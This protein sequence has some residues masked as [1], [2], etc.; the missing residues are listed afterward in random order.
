MPCCVSHLQLK[1]VF[2]FPLILDLIE[3]FDKVYNDLSWPKKL[4]FPA[5]LTPCAN[6][7]V[8]TSQIAFYLCANIYLAKPLPEC[9]AVISNLNFNCLH[10]LAQRQ[11]LFHSPSPPRSFLPPPF[12]VSPFA[13]FVC[14]NFPHLS[15]SLFAIILL[16]ILVGE[17]VGRLRSHV[18]PPPIAVPSTPPPAPAPLLSDFVSG[19][20]GLSR[21]WHWLC[22]RIW[23]S[24]CTYTSHLRC[25]FY[26]L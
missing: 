20:P 16:P 26:F 9:C 7:R 15:L 6:Y 14:Y 11:S 21:L 19:S 1:C 2:Q 18:P 24:S 13:V 3:P 5:S 4:W 17:K 10:Q 25:D 12:S 22:C 23:V 8:F